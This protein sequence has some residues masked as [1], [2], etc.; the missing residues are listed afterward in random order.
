MPTLSPKQSTCLFE[1]SLQLVV[2]VGNANIV[3]DAVTLVALSAARRV[4]LC[5]LLGMFNHADPATSASRIVHN[6]GPFVPAQAVTPWLD[7]LTAAGYAQ[8]AVEAAKTES[9]LS[10]ELA[11]TAFMGDS[12]GLSG[13]AH[14]AVVPCQR[15]CMGLPGSST[16]CRLM[17]VAGSGRCIY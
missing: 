4:L 9:Q 1:N 3:R 2:C 16:P 7:L 11:S 12:A 17:S 6:L 13:L 8:L 5:V 10:I 14:C 15:R